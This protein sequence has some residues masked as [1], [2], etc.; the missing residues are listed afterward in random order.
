M[1]RKRVKQLEACVAAYSKTR[2]AQAKE[3]SQLQCGQT[4]HVYQDWKR[5][6]ISDWYFL[7]SAT[8]GVRATCGS[9]G[10]EKFFMISDLKP[11]RIKALL[12]LGVL[13]KSDLPR[14]KP[15]KKGRRS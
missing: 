1:L 13:A 15:R 3:I 8:V 14:P 2:D 9:C 10:H 6:T 7:M 11:A 4:G 12:E 5:S